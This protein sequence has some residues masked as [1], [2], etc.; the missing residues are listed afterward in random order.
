MMREARRSR[1]WCSVILAAMLAVVLLPSA[2][3]AADDPRGDGAE[4]GNP[5][6]DPGAAASAACGPPPAAG[7][8]P[9]VGGTLP[10][11]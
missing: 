1:S 2:A 9:D 5:T 4:R 10:S 8:F 6:A 7:P 3:S 11:A